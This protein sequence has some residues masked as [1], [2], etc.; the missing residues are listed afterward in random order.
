M[1]SKDKDMENMRGK[2]EDNENR[3]GTRVIEWKI[4]W[5]TLL[6]ISLMFTIS[7]Y[8]TNRNLTTF[9]VTM[10]PT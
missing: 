9:R 1:Y 7:D 10:C 5:P 2:L 8:L 3:C 6:V 4:V